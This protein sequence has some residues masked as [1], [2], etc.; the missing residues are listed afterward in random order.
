MLLELVAEVWELLWMEHTGKSKIA[1][2][3]AVLGLQVALNMSQFLDTMTTNSRVEVPGEVKEKK[4]R[5][6]NWRSCF[7]ITS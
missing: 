2:L 1:P 3:A 5:E 4:K 6:K 7:A